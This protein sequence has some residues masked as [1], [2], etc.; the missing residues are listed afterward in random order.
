MGLIQEM[1]DLFGKIAFV[2]V[3]HEYE[4]GLYFRRGISIE[5]PVR[6]LK[7]EDLAEIKALER[8]TRDTLGRWRCFL[9]LGCTPL[10]AGFRRT[11]SGRV[12]HQRR[13]S[14][15]LRAGVYFYFPFFEHIVTDY[16]QE[17]I[18]D[19]GY[20][21]VLTSDPEP[22]SKVVIVSCNLRF[23]MMDFYRAYTAVYDYEESL[24]Y[25][26]LSILAQ[27]C[28]GRRF[29][30]WKRPETVADLEKKVVEELRK[31]VTEKWG[32]KIHQIYVTDV[33]NARIFNFVGDTHAIPHEQTMLVT[34][35]D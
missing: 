32:I 33:T 35:G 28:L 13:F 20:V 3:V 17:R 15:I 5:R 7:P 21:S 16:K 4:Q 6:R 1:A 29:E 34:A 12:R 30:D 9:G 24:R 27:K 14:K 10:P 31:L 18:L 19:L 2:T 11:W 25:H 23:E 22:E 26:A 8:S